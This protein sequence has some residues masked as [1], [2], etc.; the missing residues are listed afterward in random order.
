MKLAGIPGFSRISAQGERRMSIRRKDPL[1][2]RAFRNF[3][4]IRIARFA[5]MNLLDILNFKY[6]IIVARK[7]PPVFKAVSQNAG[8]EASGRRRK[9]T[10]ARKSAR[11][12]V[13]GGSEI[14]LNA[15]RMAFLNVFNKNIKTGTKGCRKRR[16]CG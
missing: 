14:K 15:T 4:S 11:T 13:I 3:G 8:D 1:V 16:G 5:A 12:A 6:V 2:E 9:I 10:K 7:K